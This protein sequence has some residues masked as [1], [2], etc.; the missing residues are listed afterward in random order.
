M[1]NDLQI[2]N[3]ELDNFV[4]R[5]SHDLIAPLKSL[6]GLMSITKLETKDDKMLEYVGMME[7]SVLKLE[8]FINSI[9]E[10]SVNAKSEQ[11]IQEVSIEQVIDE[12][13][14]EIK[15]FDK[16]SSIEIIKIINVQ[17][18][19]TDYKRLKIVLNNLITNAIKYHNISQENPWIKL[20]TM[21][22]NG[23]IVIEVSDNG[24]GI[25]KDHHDKIFD[26]FY[27]ASEDS[28]GSGLGLYIVKDTMKKLNGEVAIKSEINKGSTFTLTLSR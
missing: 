15:Y 24:L 23:Q 4:Y 17:T 8:K 9:M 16:N 2:A 19:N 3:T 1:N 26:M 21:Q 10:Y 7:S 14:E 6:R 18:L 12:I 5:S 13:C 20:S 25:D 28:E 22:K 27:R 11:D